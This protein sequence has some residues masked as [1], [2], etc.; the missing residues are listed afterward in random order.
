MIQ[1]P[2]PITEAIDTDHVRHLPIVDNGEI[3]V[4]AS[5]APERVLVRPRY[6]LEG[7]PGAL[8]ECFVRESVL[9][10]LLSAAA[11][12]PHGHRLVLFDA[13]R[14]LALQRW[15]F[16]RFACELEQGGELE[17]IDE[18]V[19]RPMP[20]LEHSPPYHLTGGAVDLS[21]AGPN[22][23]LLDMGSDFDAMT[24]ASHTAWFEQA[25]V[26]DEHAARWRDNRRM[27]YHAMLGAGFVNIP[28]EW[29][30]YSYGDQL[31]AAFQDQPHAI[32]GAT[33][34]AFRW[35]ELP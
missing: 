2:I 13:W 16:E 28:S 26:D 17:H 3:L 24:D 1:R 21:I 10:R 5:L 34:P 9:E 31:W 25:T 18:F 20:D 8:P 6:H 30:H 15:L 32:Y 14:P 12:L 29:W 7:L 27:L 11:N 19:S 23:R 4:P 22:G 33:E 35:G